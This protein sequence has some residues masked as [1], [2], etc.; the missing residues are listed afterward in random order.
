MPKLENSSETVIELRQRLN[1][2]IEELIEIKQH[3]DQQVEDIRESWSDHR[4]DAFKT[5]YDEGTMVVNSLAE[6]MENFDKKLI[7]LQ[8]ALII[9]ENS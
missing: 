4:Y 2:K 7:E 6:S 1:Q 3:S 8:E 9:Y 5:E